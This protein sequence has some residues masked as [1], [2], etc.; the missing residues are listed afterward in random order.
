MRVILFFTLHMVSWKKWLII[1]YFC[2]SDTNN[3][4]LQ[5]LI[6]TSSLIIT[7]WRVFSLLNLFHES[8]VSHILC[9][10]YPWCILDSNTEAGYFFQKKKSIRKVPQI[11]FY[12]LFD[13]NI[14]YCSNRQPM[15]R[16]ILYSATFSFWVEL[17][18]NSFL[19]LLLC[20]EWN[21]SSIYCSK[22]LD[23]HKEHVI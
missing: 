11:A 17:E 14:L 4:K 16:H 3:N 5:Y 6:W 18:N 1:Q 15:T 20:I 8:G 10:N 12:I 21:L 22:S 9:N 7:H 19:L 2:S 13:R 23:I